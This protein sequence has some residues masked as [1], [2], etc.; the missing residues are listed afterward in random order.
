MNYKN[1]TVLPIIEPASNYIPMIYIKD[2]AELIIVP[3][4]NF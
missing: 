3:S 2:F 1:L 4:F